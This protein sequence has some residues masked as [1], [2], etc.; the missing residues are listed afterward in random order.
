MVILVAEDEALV[1]LVLELAL[2]AAGHRVLGPVATAAGAL[3]L[4]EEGRPD[5]ALLDVNLAEGGDGA[6]V[7]RALRDRHGTPCL[8]L[9]GQV[10]QARAARDAA[11]GL[12]RKPYD[13]AGVLRAAGG[14]AAGARAVP[15][16]LAPRGGSLFRH[17][18]AA[19]QATSLARNWYSRG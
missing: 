19:E 5:L 11:W 12:V 13:P 17:G 7:A 1:A 3:R 8:F 14:P 18:Y 16:G 10:A 6:A 4:A 2:T 15:R 9:S